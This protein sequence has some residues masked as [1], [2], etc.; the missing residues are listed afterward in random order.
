MAIASWLEFRDTDRRISFVPGTADADRMHQLMAFVNSSFTS[1]FS[2]LW[3][4]MGMHPPEPAM[5]SALRTVGRKAVAK[6][7][8]QL[9]T[10][11]GDREFLVNSRPTLADAMF[12]GVA[13]SIRCGRD[14]RLGPPPLEYTPIVMAPHFNAPSWVSAMDWSV[15]SERFEPFPSASPNEPNVECGTSPQTRVRP[16]PGHAPAHAARRFGTPSKTVAL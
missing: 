15:E 2:P 14:A 1:A 12:A 4:T 6:R 16:P 8:E 3:T 13:R 7:H 11:I 10:M 9:E 5:Q